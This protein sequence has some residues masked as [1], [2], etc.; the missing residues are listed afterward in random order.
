MLPELIPNPVRPMMLKIWIGPIEKQ[1]KEMIERPIEHMV[2]H[3]APMGGGC[4]FI[5]RAGLK[6][7]GHIRELHGHKF[8]MAIAAVPLIGHPIGPQITFFKDMYLQ[9]ELAG[10]L[11]RKRVDWSYVPIQNQVGDRFFAHEP[12]KRIWP[13]ADGFAIGAIA[14]LPRPENPVTGIATDTP[15]LGAGMG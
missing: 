9:I 12:R 10:A 1:N 8:G 7:L 11:D 15:N 4:G 2:P 13:V 3:L 6:R 14:V 5:K